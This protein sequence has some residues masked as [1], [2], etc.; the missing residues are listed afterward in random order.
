MAEAA[1]FVAP[2]QRFHE[3]RGKAVNNAPGCGTIRICDCITTHTMRRT[4]VTV[5][6]S[7]GMPEAVVRKISGHSPTSKEFFRYVGVAQ[8]Y[9]DIETAKMFAKLEGLRMAV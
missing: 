6:L 3:R 8:A 7:L 5:M 9:Q 4:A 1:G 2:I